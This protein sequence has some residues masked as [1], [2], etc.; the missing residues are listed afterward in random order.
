MATGFGADAQRYDRARP[1]Y[2]DALVARIRS[3]APGV[4]V[5]D[6]GCGTGIA[7]R[8]FQAA[9]CTVLGVEPDPRMADF[10][11]AR[12]VRVEVATFEAWEPDGRM[13]DAVIAAQSWHWVDPAAGAAKAA[14]VLRPG[15]RLAIS[16]T[17]TNRR[18]RWRNRS[19]PRSGEWCRTPRSAANRHDVHSS[20]TKRDTRNSPTGFARPGGSAIPN[21]GDSTGSGP[22]RG[23]NGWSCCPPR[24][25]SPG[26]VRISWPRSSTRP[27][28]PSTLWVELSRWTTRP[29]PPPPPAQARPDGRGTRS[30][31][32]S[33]GAATGTALPGRRR[34]GHA[35]GGT[36]SAVPW[37]RGLTVT[38]PARHT[39]CRERLCPRGVVR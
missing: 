35:I 13:F 17:C 34:A 25:A 11:R 22:I 20:S 10:A 37:N 38:R 32:G 16:V 1:G 7:A 24:A 14:G 15:G 18:P 30:G 23:T 6:V 28:T 33:G 9:G 21:S 3:G 27:G 12:G 31:S 4:S 2:P 26:S 5:L 29:W 19:P 39:L 36:G 8:Q